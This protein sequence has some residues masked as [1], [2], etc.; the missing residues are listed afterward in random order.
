MRRASTTRRRFLQ[1]VAGTGVAS[2]VALAATTPPPQGAA[3]TAIADRSLLLEFDA[4]MRSRAFHLRRDAQRESHLALTAWSVTE[5]LLLKDG[6]TLEQFALG[7]AEHA[8]LDSPRGP[9]RRLTLT[10]RSSSGI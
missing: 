8:T 7:D 1:L 5:S 4:S 9:G 3:G 10:G 6:S 2:R